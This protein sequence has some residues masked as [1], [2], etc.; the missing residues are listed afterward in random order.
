MRIPSIVIIIALLL[1][2]CSGVQG[3]SLIIDEQL[4]TDEID[5]VRILM[6][7]GQIKVTKSADDLIWINAT[8]QQPD[9]FTFTQGEG[10]LEIKNE[11]STPEDYLHIKIPAGIILDIIAFDTNIDLVELEGN[12]NIRTTAGNITMLDTI[13]ETYLWAG[14]GDIKI[15]RGEGQA[16]VI[17]EHGA[18]T[19]SEFSG[20]VSIT[21]IMGHIQFTGIENNSGDILL[22]VDHG[23]VQAVLPDKTNYQIAVDSASGDVVCLGGDLQRTITGCTGSTGDGV[24]ILRIRTVSGR[25][26]FQILP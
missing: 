13:G 17:G 6:D 18:L 25:I 15:N 9:H 4:S 3:K 22:E 12:T 19:V 8:A 1:S 10:S 14:R 20:P 2:C 21:T 24:G 16:V 23:S 11:D 7:R 5:S 26:E